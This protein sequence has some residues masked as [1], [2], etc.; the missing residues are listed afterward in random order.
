MLVGEQLGSYQILEEIGKG[1]MATVYRARQPSM[2][3]DV[4][5]KVIRRGLSDPAAVQRFQREARLIARLEH[6]H[7]LPVYDF[8]GAHDPPYIVMRYLDGGTLEGVLARGA[9]DGADIAALARQ[10]CSGLDYAHRQ[11]VIHRDIK[12]SNILIDRDGNAFVSDFGIARSAAGPQSMRITQ[13]GIVLGSV[14]YMSPEQVMGRRDLDFRA[15]LYALGAMLFQLL[16]GRLPFVSDPPLGVLAMHMQAPVPAASSVNPALP[17][18]VDDVFR[19]AMEKKPEDRFRSA[20]ELSA[21]L[22]AALLGASPAPRDGLRESAHLREVISIPPPPERI[23]PEIFSHAPIVEHNRQIVALYANAAE[24][25]EMIEAVGDRETAYRAMVSLWDTFDRI[26]LDAGGVTLIRTDSD[27]LAVWGAASAHEDDA[28]RA[29]RAALDMQGRLRDLMAEHGG[30]GQSLLD[31]QIPLNIGIHTGMALVSP[32]TQPDARTGAY[33]IT[34][35]TVSVAN[36]LMQSAYGTVLITHDVYRMVRGV[37]EAQ[38]DLPLRVRGRTEGVPIYRVSA[39]KP[40]AFRPTTRGVEGLETRL[41]GRESELRRLQNAFLNAVEDAETQVVT[42]TGEAGVGKS[43]M[44]DAFDNWCELR[45]EMYYL[46]RGRAAGNANRPYALLRDIITYRFQIRADDASPVVVQKLEEGIASM[47][48]GARG[49]PPAAVESSRGMAH[50]IGYLC[51]FD[52]SASPELRP[53]MGD[54]ALMAAQAR[55]AFLNLVFLLSG[56]DYVLFELEDLHLADDASLDLLTELFNSSAESRKDTH[57]MIACTARPALFSRR[58]DWGSRPFHTRVDLQPLDRR[59]SRELVR[60]I[61]KKIPEVPRQLRDLL[62]ERAEGNPY[63]MEELVKMLLDDRVIVMESDTTWR[64]E[65]GRLGALKVPPSL[66]ALIEARL[67]TLLSPERLVLLRAAVFGRTFYL[68]VL[69]AMDEAD[70]DAHGTGAHVAD[71]KGV[72]A[73]LSNRAFIHVREGAAFAGSVEYSFAQTMLRDVVYDLLLERQRK[74]YHR[75]AAEWI[76]SLQRADEYLLSIADHYEQAGEWA[77]ASQ[78]LHRAGDRSCKRGLFREAEALY[79]RGLADL[80]GDDLPMRLALLLGVGEAANGRGDLPRAQPALEEALELAEKSGDAGAQ[81][82]AC[83]LLGMIETSQGRFSSAL[84]LLDQALPLSRQQPD[85]RVLG[86]V[87]YGLA[88]AYF[89]SG[90]YDQ[91]MDAAEECC[92]LAEDLGDDA[93]RVTA[94][95]RIA[96]VHEMR[97]EKDA[98]EAVLKETL[99]LARSIGHRRVETSALIN[100]GVLHMLG[101]RLKEAA[102][103]WE[104]ALAITREAGDLFAANVVTS[105]L[106]VAYARLGVLEKVMP[107]VVECLRAAK[108][109]R[110]TPGL[111]RGVLALGELRIAEGDLPAGLGLLGLARRHPAAPADHLWGADRGLEFWR[112]KMGMDQPAI[113]AAMAEGAK[114]ELEKVVAQVLKK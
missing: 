64:V 36:R 92:I 13:E 28:E 7:I 10:I 80:P 76:S 95:N 93:M 107:L 111:L 112:A 83:Y 58:P 37:F 68:G 81:A 14:E 25:A 9:L 67:D 69:Q 78:A 34:G 6:P 8:D 41:V 45:P 4:A 48:R 114:L 109:M 24:Y 63:Y 65:E 87:L 90:R 89:R 31:E 51:G 20:V 73:A 11:G 44:L 15:D 75:A 42:I 86:N 40:R 66:A 85:R 97:F 22:D 102:A 32:V 60:E 84:A 33:T 82:T 57:L 70:S 27:L 99:D 3:R 46:F 53:L 1:G 39:A 79:E 54:P 100:V 21:M 17:P 23:T 113:D 16:T 47:I 2:D 77:K 104:G 88:E 55:K 59:E 101:G 38:P 12:P 30:A 108:Q 43:R 98:A 18:E 110:S 56:S 35:A 52:L 62:V 50:R 96:T 26:V 103:V 72:L 91:A 94:M 105:N 49:L 106:G 61:L 29:V 71:L 19:R 74:V 5:L